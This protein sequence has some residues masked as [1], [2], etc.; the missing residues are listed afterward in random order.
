MLWG[1]VWYPSITAA[2]RATGE[3]Y[4]TMQARHAQGI[5]SPPHSLRGM[6]W[7]GKHYPTIKACHEAT[8]IEYNRLR[9]Y[10][11]KGITRLADVGHS[12][13]ASPVV[14]NGVRYESQREAAAA[15]GISA[16]AMTYRVQQG[17][18]C[19]DDLLKQRTLK[20]D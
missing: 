1:G 19:D 13:E 18:A 2:A 16:N 10:R 14:W 7:E 8:G 9:Y 12:R 6:R 4:T 11:A 5:T 15:L 3:K 20:S 17:Y